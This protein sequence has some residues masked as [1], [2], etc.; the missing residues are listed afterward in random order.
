ML[1]IMRRRAQP[2]R[3][4][5]ATVCIRG[6]LPWPYRMLRLCLAAYSENLTA[7]I[8][9]DRSQYTLACARRSSSRHAPWH[10]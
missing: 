10:T 5:S 8:A 7:I 6:I 4:S 3:R 9:N 1:L 2:H